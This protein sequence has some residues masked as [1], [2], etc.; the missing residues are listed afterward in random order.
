MC[1]WLN[2]SYGVVTLWL[3]NDFTSLWKVKN[4]PYSAVGE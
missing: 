3:G 4:C 2:L 1:F